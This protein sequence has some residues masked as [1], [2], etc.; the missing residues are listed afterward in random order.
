M[1]EGFVAITGGAS[2][3]GFAIAEACLAKGW[4]VAIADQNAGA[5]DAAERQLAP[6]GSVDGT[7]LD[8]TDEVAIEAW[9]D[10]IAAAG[11]LVGVVTAA[12]IAADV[13]FLDTT[14]D[15]FRRIHDVNVLGTF[16]V[17]RTAARVMR[18][19]G[20]GSLVTIASV[21]G[22]R[23]SKGRAA[24]G[25][26]KAAVINLTQVMAVDLARYGIR[27]NAVC[28]GPVDTPLVRTMHDAATRKAW[29]DH[30]PQ[31]RYAEPR[32]ITGLVTFLLDEE[33]SSFVTGQAIAVDGGFAA[34]GLTALET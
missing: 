6:Q 19:T 31:R 16:L 30:V 34:A 27:A 23:G 33:A 2:G 17:C 9:I 32:E 24:Y 18:A 15:R 10:R 1:R 21:A 14:A 25:S 5:L 26:S 11:R 13:P 7:T 22:L 4:G 29:I 28:P 8:V 3:I 20:G 12:G